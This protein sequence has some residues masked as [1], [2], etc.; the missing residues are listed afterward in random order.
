MIFYLQRLIIHIPTGAVTGVEA[1]AKGAHSERKIS[2]GPVRFCSFEGRAQSCG[3]A[4]GQRC[5]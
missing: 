3:H 2:A 4:T 1:A 5:T